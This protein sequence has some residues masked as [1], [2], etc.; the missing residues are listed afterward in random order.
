MNRRQA[1]Q[2][3][4][5]EVPS[6][7]VKL[8]GLGGAGSNLVNALAGRAE[9][10]E[11]VVANTDR[12]ALEG[13]EVVGRRI[14]LGPQTT[15]GWGAG[16]DPQ[17]GRAA[18]EES[19]Q[20]LSRA[21]AGADLVVIA[22]GMGGGTGTGSAPVAARLARE[23]GALVL[24]IVTMPFDV[25]RGQRTQNAERGLAALREVCDAVVVVPN[26]QILRFAD[27]EMTMATA[28]RLADKIVEAATAGVID[29]LTLPGMMRL[30]FSYIRRV[31]T[32]SGQSLLGIGSAVGPDAAIQAA[33]QAV[34]CDLLD[35]QVDRSRR[36]FISLV[37]GSDMGLLD[38]NAAVELI[39]RDLDP[40]V[41]IVIGAATDHRLAADRVRVTMI[42]GAVTSQRGQKPQRTAGLPAAQANRS[43]PELSHWPQPQRGAA[44][45]T[46]QPVEEPLVAAEDL[47][48]IDDS[49]LVAPPFLTLKRRG[50]R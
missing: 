2:A 8:I 14:L 35:G 33:R 49:E 31:L 36:V 13:R 32:Q 27:R 24:A 29:A 40:D 17:V 15:H 41:D 22:A 9:R 34:S 28:M 26:E 37:G 25:E 48:A 10:V 3:A 30:D 45:R 11:L 46:P 4:A 20:E 47:A 44:L 43:Q 5:F 23:S 12:Q 1:Q 21:L 42:A 18:A 16:S 6:I 19:R 50:R 7:T 39:T 38:V